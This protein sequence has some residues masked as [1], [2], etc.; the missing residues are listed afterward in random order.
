[1]VVSPSLYKDVSQMDFEDSRR[2]ER[3][4][5]RETGAEGDR[6][7]LFF[8]HFQFLSFLSSSIPY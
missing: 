2:R 3:E 6:G 1:M 5:G 4:R 8:A 7:R